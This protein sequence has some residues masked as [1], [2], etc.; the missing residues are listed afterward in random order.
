MSSDC[1]TGRFMVTI[2]LLLVISR[3]N[4]IWEGAS[5]EAM[6]VFVTP[7]TREIDA[8]RIVG[9]QKW[10]VRCGPTVGQ[11]QG[12]IGSDKGLLT[13]NLYKLNLLSACASSIW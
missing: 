6:I 2:D 13:G 11:K 5:C 9:Y 8:A 4:S 1:M 12:C 3:D 10:L 7:S